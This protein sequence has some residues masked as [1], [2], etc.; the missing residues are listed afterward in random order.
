MVFDRP[1]T[2]FEQPGYRIAEHTG[3]GPVRWSLVRRVVIHYTAAKTNP[4][5][6]T[7]VAAKL[8]ASQRDY[9][10]NRE[11]HVSIGY[12][13]AADQAGLLWQLRGEEYECAANGT[14]AINIDAVA[15]LCLVNGTDAANPPM[16][17]AV[18]RFVA[19]AEGRAGRELAI[20]G[21]GT[22]HPT[23]CPGP[24][25][26]SQITAGT[27]R[28]IP[29]SPPEDTDMHYFHVEGSSTPPPIFAS[30]D[31]LTAVHVQPAQWPQLPPGPVDTISRPAAGRFTFVGGNPPAGHRGIW[32]NA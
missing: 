18:R 23:Q 2:A 29:P 10:D 13:G 31:G 28:P 21:H 17:D 16:V 6:A 32:A 1:R 9:V 25:L 27:F 22:I 11:A 8:A 14:R 15:L 12:T 7:A 3:S 26:H 19:W 30:A 5:L 4:V 24:G 20:V